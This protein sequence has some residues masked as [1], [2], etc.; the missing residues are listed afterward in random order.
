VQIARVC[1]HVVATLKHPALGARK[2]LLVQPYDLAGQPRG[3]PATA[4]DVVD[5]GPG[6]WVL[7]LDEGSSAS[8]VLESPRGPVRTLVV[9]VIDAVASGNPRSGP[10]RSGNP[11]RDKGLTARGRSGN[12]PLV[13]RSE[14]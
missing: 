6:D 1:G 2:L 10:G 5:A 7:V 14:A 11:R 9:G 12:D 13:P 8:Q 3:R 4:L